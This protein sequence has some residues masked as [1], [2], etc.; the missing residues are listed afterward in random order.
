MN[1]KVEHIQN[2]L[3]ERLETLRQRLEEVKAN[4]E[5]SANQSREALHQKG[6]EIEA[7]Y[8]A[9]QQKLEDAQVRAEQWLEDKAA[10]TGEKIAEWE[11]QHEVEKLERRADRAEEYAASAVYL[12][13]AAID[14]AELAI[15]DAIGARLLAEDAKCGDNEFVVYTGTY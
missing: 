15:L 14:E 3:N 6:Q 13:S 5:D 9:Q 10:E 2:D 7:R 12:A 8:K 4:V 1:Q 11:H